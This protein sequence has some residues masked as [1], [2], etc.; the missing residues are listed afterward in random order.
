[1]QVFFDTEFTGL[2]QATTLISIGL[3]AADGRTFYA[4]FN[5][6]DASQLN[7]WLWEHVMPYLQLLDTDVMTPPLD[8]THHLMK[9][10]RPR[11][12][13]ALTEWLAQF[14][15]VELWADYPAYDWVLFGELFG[16]GLN[17]PKNIANNAL[18]VATL[19]KAAGVDVQVDRQEFAGMTEMNL[20]NALDDAKLAK[21]CYKKA[22]GILSAG[23]NDCDG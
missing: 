17:I 10:D 11:V 22:I 12:T 19:L 5:D 15:T 13:R 20:H 4:E 23:D 1:M 14:E 7:D 9:A 2:R 3:I 8:L 16:G 21:A 6:Y 18:D